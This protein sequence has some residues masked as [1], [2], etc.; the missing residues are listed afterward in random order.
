MFECGFCLRQEGT[1]RR[2]GCIDG[3]LY[4]RTI[5]HTYFGP[6]EYQPDN[7]YSPPSKSVETIIGDSSTGALKSLL[8]LHLLQRGVAT[9]GGRFFVLSAAHSEA[10]ADRTI[11]AFA[12][13]LDD[14]K[15]EGVFD[16]K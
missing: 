15:H 9:M 4:G 10:D 8:G 3:R 1:K 14:M 16:G 7:E 2:N 6:I 5:I 11:G 13:A 12:E